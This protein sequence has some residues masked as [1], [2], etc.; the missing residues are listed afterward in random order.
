MC[1]VPENSRRLSKGRQ[2]GKRVRAPPA[3]VLGERERAPNLL[4]PK[5]TPFTRKGSELEGDTST[6]IKPSGNFVIPV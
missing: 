2:G 4:T 5:L 6:G 1:V 3:T